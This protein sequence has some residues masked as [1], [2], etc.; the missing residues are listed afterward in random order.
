MLAFCCR[1]TGFDT[2]E[3]EAAVAAFAGLTAGRME[4]GF[5]R[6]DG[7]ALDIDLPAVPDV[8]L[9]WGPPLLSG[10]LV[11]TLEGVGTGEDFEVGSAGSRNSR[12][13]IIAVVDPGA[14]VV[15]V[16]G[17]GVDAGD[18]SPVIVATTS[19]SMREGDAI[20]A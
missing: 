7:E 15:E 14:C 4:V 9:C 13:P 11:C 3:D 10:V 18:G 12:P 6:C 17:V 5:G 20:V 2:V 19:R 16:D 1:G 8:T